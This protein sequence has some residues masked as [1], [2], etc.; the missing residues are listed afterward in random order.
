MRN[1]LCQVGT[2]RKRGATAGAGS[3]HPR[4][5]FSHIHTSPA[6]D[7]D[8]FILLV[9]A[10]LDRLLRLLRPAKSLVLAMDGPAPLAKLLTQRSRRKKGARKETRAVAASSGEGVDEGEDDEGGGA[11]S[12]LALTPGTPVMA[13]LQ[14]ALEYWCLARLGRP[15]RG[16]GPPAS[17]SWGRPPAI[18]LSSAG[19]P[20]EGELKLLARLLHPGGAVSGAPT[21][22]HCVVG[23]DSDLLLMAMGAPVADRAVWVLTDDGRSSGGGG[24][25]G[26]R[27]RGRGGPPRGAPLFFSVAGLDAALQR[28]Q[29]G[30]GREEGK[31]AAAASLPRPPRPLPAPPPPPPSPASAAARRDLAAISIMTSG[32]DYLP[33]VRG[34]RLGPTWRAY[35]GATRPGGPLAGRALVVDLPPAPRSSS[36]PLV[37]LDTAVLLHLLEASGGWRGGAAWREAQREGQAAPPPPPSALNLP[38]PPAPRAAAAA[39]AAPVA[40]LSLDTDEDDEPRPPADPAAYLDGLAWVL[41]MYASGVCPDYR[42]VYDARGPGVDQVAAAA[43]AAGAGGGGL[44]VPTRLAGRPALPPAVCAAALLP[45]GPR[46]RR[47]APPS[48]RPL[49]DAGSP[50]ADLYTVCEKC[51]A[52]ADASGQ[53]QAALAG[54]VG[55]LKAATDGFPQP[56]LARGGAGR[57]RGRPPRP[58]PPR[59]SPPV[60]TSKDALTALEDRVDAARAR[61]RT[62]A[63]R[64][65]AHQRSV[66]PY[67]PFPL[68]RLEAAVRG[69][70]SAAG[71]VVDDDE[72]GGSGV[73]AP[74]PEA[75]L[76]FDEPRLYQR[77]AGPPRHAP[78]GGSGRPPLITLPPPPTPRLSP[79]EPALAAEVFVGPAGG[80]GSVG[81]R[82]M[83]GKG[84]PHRRLPL[85]GAPKRAPRPPPPAPPRVVMMM[86]GRPAVSGRHRP[87]PVLRRGSPTLL[88]TL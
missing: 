1:H 49:W 52:L 27:G 19:V 69:A 13:R 20:G 34:L 59:P 22:T 71:G 65:R 36:P 88:A 57:G 37:G 44:W 55:A 16:G 79:L 81:V 39:A 85:V 58:S 84:P 80:G 15:A 28:A 53:A 17:P 25:G 62:V 43:A 24:G 26:G 61:A 56:A 50:V 33:S 23:G 10:R 21:D 46:G 29:A 78:G 9:F 14:G 70:L 54:A 18:E 66:H 2:R 72:A 74:P 45:P 11:L 51:E 87:A 30:G 32:N 6:K 60:N 75:L 8:H 83:T 3:P 68:A 4:S 64:A 73:P 7:P 77:R 47:L 82:P 38:P 41:A 76:S 67:A 5:P 63:A 31:G 40:S 42:F 48:L 35:L 12:S 86:L